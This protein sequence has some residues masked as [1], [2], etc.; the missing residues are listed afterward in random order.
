MTTSIRFDFDRLTDGQARYVADQ[1]TASLKQL[2]YPPVNLHGDVI[3]HDEVG[4]RYV[5]IVTNLDALDQPPLVEELI[6]GGY[7]SAVSRFYKFMGE[8]S[9]DDLQRGVVNTYEV[10]DQTIVN[11]VLGVRVDYTCGETHEVA[12]YL[13]DQED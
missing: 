6:T 5:L 12:L 7:T 13:A 4:P 1:M 3:Q 8:V 10:M 11:L 9:E 2:N